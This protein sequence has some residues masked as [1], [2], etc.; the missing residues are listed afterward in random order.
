M[1]FNFDFDFSDHF[2]LRN[3]TSPVPLITPSWLLYM[4]HLYLP[5]HPPFGMPRVLPVLRVHRDRLAATPSGH[6]ELFPYFEGYCGTPSSA[7][8]LSQ[9]SGAVRN[10]RSYRR[11]VSAAN[12]RQ[13]RITHYVRRQSGPLA[14]AA[15]VDAH[16]ADEL[17]SL[18]LTEQE[19]LHLLAD[20]KGITKYEHI[21]LLELCGGCQRMFAA[22][23]LRA[24]ILTCSQ[25]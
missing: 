6:A 10:V 8:A 24:H 16:V 2:S 25:N 3:T 12:M 13:Q 17:A 21:G 22:S 15:A 4:V 18:T 20:G 7:L 1:E 11:R 19:I 14:S 9:Q 5:T 23:A